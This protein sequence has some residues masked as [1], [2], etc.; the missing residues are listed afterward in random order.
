MNK[1]LEGLWGRGEGGR[2]MSAW[3]KSSDLQ[4]IIY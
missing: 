2:F 1:Y 3:I 4:H